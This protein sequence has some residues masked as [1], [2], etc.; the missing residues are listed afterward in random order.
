MPD[1]HG[2]GTYRNLSS[3]DSATQQRIVEAT[4]YQF[5]SITEY[6]AFIV[7]VRCNRMF[8]NYPSYHTFAEWSNSV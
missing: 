1:P 2:T 7:I 8:N 4:D 5:A 3:Y 6:T